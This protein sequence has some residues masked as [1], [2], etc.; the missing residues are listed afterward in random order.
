MSFSYGW[1]PYVSVAQRKAKATKKVAALKKKGVATSPVIIQGRSIARTFWGKSW[2]DNLESYQDHSNRLPRGRSY[3]RNGSVIDLKLKTGT[4]EA[5]VYGSSLYSVDISIK[6]LVDVDWKALIKKC[7]GKIDSTIELLQGKFSKAVMEIIIDK[8]DGLFPHDHEIEFKCSCPDYAIMCK[9]VAAV[10]YGVGARLDE[11]PEEL[12]KLRQVDYLNLITSAISSEKLMQDTS[13][14]GSATI[15][16]SDLS[17]LFGID[18]DKKNIPHKKSKKIT[19]QKTIIQKK[20]SKEK[21]KKAPK[22]QTSKAKKKVG[23]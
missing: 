6:P 5:L 2:C 14:M 19:P 7:T 21:T 20:V 17:A 22:A 12:F 8:N 11:K 1:K 16:E 9:H 15:D 3:V 13:Q 23:A 4:I 18:I 10:L